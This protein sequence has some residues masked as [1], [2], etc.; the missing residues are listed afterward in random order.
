MWRATPT[1]FFLTNVIGTVLAGRY[2]ENELM[3]MKIA[4]PIQV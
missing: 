4:K 2:S 1:I 3:I